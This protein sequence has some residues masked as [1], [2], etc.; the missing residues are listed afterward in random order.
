MNFYLI[1]PPR[2]S[3]KF[4]LKTLY[5]L[6]KILKID[7]LQLRPKYNSKRENMDFIKKYF[8][9]FRNFCTENNIFFIIN[10]NLELVKKMGFDGVH[11][12]QSDEN[13]KKA[14]Y[15]LGPKYQIGISCQNS[16]ELSLK[17][18]KEGAN[19]V[20]FG[21][22]Y[23]S[24]TKKNNRKYLD[25]EFIKKN[26]KKIPLPYTLIGGI[27]H[28]EI[29]SFKDIK[30]KNIAVINSIWNFREG[31]IESAKKY[32]ELIKKYSS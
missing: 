30:P 32:K 9:I 17:A 20:A 4:N 31:P 29:S 18:K 2:F 27:S 26:E 5:N 25:L 28:R 12:G 16:I 3:K 7:C 13:C 23:K 14:R 21:P 19:Y 10:N 11:L 22:V 6:S 24:K 8:S 15:L 1:S